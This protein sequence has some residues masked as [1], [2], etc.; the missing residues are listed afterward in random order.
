MYVDLLKQQVT[1]LIL[2][3]NL[4]F[5]NVPLYQDNCIMTVQFLNFLFNTLIE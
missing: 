4:H 3:H 2:R 5:G 1:I